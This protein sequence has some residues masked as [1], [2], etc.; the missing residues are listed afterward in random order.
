MQRRTRG[1]FSHR[2]ETR[3]QVILPAGRSVYWVSIGNHLGSVRYP[4]DLLDM[5]AIP[6]LNV[7]PQDGVAALS[8]EVLKR[9]GPAR[10]RAL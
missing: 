4:R 2:T 5:V 10:L 7:L 8:R 1:T 6:L 3:P 9:R